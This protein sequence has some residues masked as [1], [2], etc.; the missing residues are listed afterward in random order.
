MANPVKGDTA[1]VEGMAVSVR[2]VE[3][4]RL[5]RGGIAEREIAK[6]E[7]P[8]PASAAGEG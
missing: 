1:N 5:A 2:V 8:S 3:V 4:T 6:C 7:K